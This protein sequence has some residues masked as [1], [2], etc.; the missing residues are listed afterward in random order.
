MQSGVRDHLQRLVHVLANERRNLGQLDIR[1]ERDD[2]GNGLAAGERR[3]ADR[4]CLDDIALGIDIVLALLD[5]NVQ[6]QAEGVQLLL[7]VLP[8]EIDQRRHFRLADARGDGQLDGAADLRLLFRQRGLVDN[9]ARRILA[10]FDVAVDLNDE[11]RII[12]CPDLVGGQ[13]NEPRDSRFLR[14]SKQAGEEIIVQE[15]AD[16]DHGQRDADDAG[17]DR[18]A[19]AAPGGVL[20]GL[21]VLLELL[22]LRDRVGKRALDRVRA[23]QRLGHIIGVVQQALHVDAVGLGGKVKDD[24]RLLAEFLQ[25]VEHTGRRGIA[26]RQLRR[27]GVH[28]DLLKAERNGGVQ[29]TRHGGMAVNVLNG[30]RNGRI[31]VIR[32]AARQHFVHDDAE[33]IEVG[34]AVDLRALGLLGRDIVDGA[35]RLAREGVLCGGDAGNAEVRDLDAAVLQNHD[36]MGLDVTVDDAAAV[37]VLKCLADLRGEVQG[38]APV[39]RALL[40]HILLEGNALDQL[41]DDVVDVV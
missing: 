40:L 9:D 3:I 4:V 24:V 8:R 28:G 5:L 36:I 21:F 7:G 38:L 31:A 17:D 33:R 20:L 10:A 2:E 23:A 1:A 22:F 34:A 14:L 15:I 30:D 39:E 19:A 27:H 16:D 12:L 29:L 37:R 41:H 13:A 32:R 6:V 35:E 26:V 11:V 25:I 18:D